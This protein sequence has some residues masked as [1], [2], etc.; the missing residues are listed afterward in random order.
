MGTRKMEAQVAG[1]QIRWQSERCKTCAW[2]DKQCKSCDYMLRTGRARSLICPPGDA[3][4]VY[5][6]AAP[7]ENWSRLELPPPDT[8]PLMPIRQRDGR[9]SAGRRGRIDAERA[10][11]LWREG[12]SDGAIARELGVSSP[13]I[14]QWRTREGLA[15]RYPGTTKGFWSFSEED[16]R[17][18]HAEGLSDGEIARRLGVHRKTISRWRYSRKLPCNFEKRGRKRDP[19]L[20]SG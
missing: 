12:M 4:T 19:S 16:A 3:C 2:S 14:Q 6:P 17:E 15:A 18:L 8:R 13:A 5:E 10:R 11:A 20:R 7:G 1:L 9:E